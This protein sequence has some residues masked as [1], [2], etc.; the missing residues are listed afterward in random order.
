M[1]GNAILLTKTLKPALTLLRELGVRLVAYID[2]I[3]VMTETEEIA[4]PYLQAAGGPGL[5]SPLREISN[6]IEMLHSQ[7]DHKALLFHSRV[8]SFPWKQ[9]LAEICYGFIL[10][11]SLAQYGSNSYSG[12]ISLQWNV[13][14]NTGWFLIKGTLISI[15]FS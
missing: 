2:N 9:F 3:L 7:Y 11:L 8:C 12:C 14:V 1:Q 13:R 15:Y 10:F 4:R 5:H 6:L